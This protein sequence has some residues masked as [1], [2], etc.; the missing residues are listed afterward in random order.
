MFRRS[1][2]TCL[3]LVQ[4]S[5]S[6]SHTIWAVWAATMIYDDDNDEGSDSNGD[7]LSDGDGADDDFED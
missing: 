6:D 1:L 7:G 3:S 4:T 5:W 2:Y